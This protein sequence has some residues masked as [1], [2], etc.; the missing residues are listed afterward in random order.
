MSAFPTQ[1]FLDS[2]AIA[3]DAEALRQRAAESGYLYF[4]GLLEPADTVEGMTCG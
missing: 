3:G 1:P 2:A 4:S